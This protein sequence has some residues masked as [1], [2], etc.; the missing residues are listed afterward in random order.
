M[1]LRSFPRVEEMS[2]KEGLKEKYGTKFYAY[3]QVS[4]NFGSWGLAVTKSFF[5]TN[6]WE[7]GLVQTY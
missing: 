6:S 3:K 7:S 4:S 5:T 1:P 2:W